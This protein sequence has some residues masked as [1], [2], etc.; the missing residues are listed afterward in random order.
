MSS[1]AIHPA[2]LLLAAPTTADELLPN[3]IMRL[4]VP[5]EVP[6]AAVL[7]HKRAVRAPQRGRS[8]LAPGW[9]GARSERAGRWKG[10]SVERK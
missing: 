6:R 1:D 4:D 2:E 7:L 3:P 8:G 10:E 9:R 5:F